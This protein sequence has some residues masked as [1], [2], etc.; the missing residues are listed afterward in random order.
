MGETMRDEQREIRA[1]KRRAWE[2]EEALV[3]KDASLARR[4]EELAELTRM[5]EDQRRELESLTATPPWLRPFRRLHTVPQFPV[6]PWYK[7]WFRRVKRRIPQRTVRTIERSSYF[8]A[9]WYLGQ[10][11]SLARDRL[12]RRNPALHYLKKGG[13]EGLD[14][15]PDFDSDWYLQQYP[16]VQAIGVN[17][18]L[19]YLLHGAEEGRKIRPHPQH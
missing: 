12:A 16:D 10:Y 14:P 4:Y 13:F 7:W 11:P 18:L 6:M 3:E 15:G 19:H 5:M 8:D 1:L 2:L 9:R 17:P